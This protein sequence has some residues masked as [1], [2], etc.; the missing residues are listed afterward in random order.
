MHLLSGAT[1]L[2]AFLILTDPVTASTT[3]RVA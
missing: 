3:N 1:M 2:G